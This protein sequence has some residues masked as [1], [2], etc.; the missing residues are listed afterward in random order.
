MASVSPLEYTAIGAVAG[1]T[2]VLV[3]MPT[4]SIKNALQEGRQLPRS[5]PAFYR[6]LAVNS[7]ANF[8]ITAVQFGANRLLGQ[9]YQQLVGREPGMAGRVAVAMGA[10]ATSALISC[11]AEFLVIQQQRT[12]QPLRV[13]A[14]RVLR[15][16]GPLSLYKG[17]GAT[18]VRASLYTASYMIALPWLR[19]HLQHHS[20]AGAV[21]GASLLGAG[22]CAGLLG[23]LATQPADTIKTR[24]QA[25]PDPASHPAYRSMLSA[26]RE[27]VAQRGVR[28]LFNGLLPRA[29]RNC[30][31]VIILNAC[32]TELVGAIDDHRILAARAAAA[33]AAAAVRSAGEAGI[34]VPTSGLAAA[35]AA[36]AAAATPLPAVSTAER[37]GSRGAGTQ[38][39]SSPE[40][41]SPG[42]FSAACQ[43]R[44][45]SP[46]F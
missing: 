25:F 4:V 20:P 32:L 14:A 37:G 6:G 13:E 9:A 12:G 18:V 35:A 26:G 39:T 46:S 10:G 36:E 21:P 27:I 17:L 45:T 43:G 11:P 29:F 7:C 40:E 30:G 3:M 28:G 22:I 42:S 38:R 34:T 19:E 23:T 31:A 44:P 24:M 41:L 8:P 33:A 15:A 2:E 5:L 16:L 1:V